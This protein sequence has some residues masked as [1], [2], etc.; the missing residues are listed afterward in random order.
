[1]A[2]EEDAAVGQ[3]LQRRKAAQRM[4]VGEGVVQERRLER[5]QIEAPG[6]GLGLVRRQLDQAAGQS[7]A[8]V[9]ANTVWPAALIGPSWASAGGR[10]TSA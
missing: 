7:W 10:T 3:A 4:V 1:M 5:R 9:S 2:R 6:E 8:S